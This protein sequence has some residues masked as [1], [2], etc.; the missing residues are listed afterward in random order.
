MS[1]PLLRERTPGR[2]ARVTFLELFFD[3]VFVFAITRISHG[4]IEHLTWAGAL[5]AGFMLLAVWWAWV[6]TT[7]FTNWLDPE[8][9]LVRLTLF[10]AMALGLV[11]STTLSEA[12]DGKAMAFALAYWG[13]Q[14]GRTLFT[15]WAT[16][17]ER[18]L[19]LTFVRIAAWFAVSGVFW[20]AGALA[21]DHAT[22]FAL[23]GLALFLEYLAVAV[24]FWTPGLG[25]ARTT[26]WNVE[27]AHMAERCGLF[28]IICLGESVLVTGATFADL[29]WTAPV[30]GAFAAAFL[31]TIAMWWIYFS[32]HAEAASEAIAASADPGRIARL[33]YTFLHIPLV[34]G[35][36]VVA[37][38]DELALAHALGHV[39]P[40]TAIVLLGGPALFLLGALLFKFSVFAVWSP[41]R[42]TG[43]VL[44]AALAPAALTL[45]PLA[46]SI[47]ASGVLALVG[48]LEAW[49]RHRN[50]YPVPEVHIQEG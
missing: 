17:G 39:E 9:P 24:A 21:Q 41:T 2:R 37:A 31:G 25:R 12:F 34:A 10:A 29:D 8:H 3:L 16:R 15:I 20:I 36:I 50:P 19:H 22:R 47:A 43:L 28:I 35:I 38:G 4:L 44:L 5:E 26:D 14:F 18:L 42:L 6:F 11:L 45:S 40:S 1:M 23:W 30:L 46:L 48:G 32:A 27:G 13:L 7:W 33:A 49:Q